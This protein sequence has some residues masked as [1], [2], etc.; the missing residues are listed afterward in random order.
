MDHN[1]DELQQ[2]VDN[3]TLSLHIMSASL[4]RRFAI[5]VFPQPYPFSTQNCTH[6]SQHRRSVAPSTRR[7]V[8]PSCHRVDVLV[9]VSMRQYFCHSMFSL[10]YLRLFSPVIDL[11]SIS[12]AYISTKDTSSEVTSVFVSTPLI[13]SLALSYARQQ[14]RCD[15]TEPGVIK[16][17]TT[18]IVANASTSDVDSAT[19]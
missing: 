5:A 17:V 11:A 14:C 1:V 9:L 15:N 8:D 4:R 18:S 16:V 10:V 12:N 13:I 7:L 6:A 3:T 19:R 2:G